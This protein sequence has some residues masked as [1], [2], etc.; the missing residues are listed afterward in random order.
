MPTHAEALGE[1]YEH[2]RREVLAREVASRLGL[3]VFL[4]QG[5]V[6]W[7]K[8]QALRT[9]V[10]SLATRRC[11]QLTPLPKGL[12]GDLTRIL[13]ELILTRKELAS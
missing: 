6:G 1:R 13:T 12:A 8:V 10:P 3:A 4:R 9:A 11:E 2:L 5:M 7:M